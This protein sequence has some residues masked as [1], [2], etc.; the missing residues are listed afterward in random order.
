MNSRLRSL[1]ALWLLLSPAVLQAQTSTLVAV[2]EN[3]S[4]GSSLN[5]VFLSEGYTSAQMGTFAANVQTAVNF[6]FSKEP[7]NRYRSYCNV[8]RIE[9]AS[10]Q[11]GTDNGAAGGARDT[12]WPQDNTPARHSHA[13]AGTLNLTLK[14][15]AHGC[16]T[17]QP[18]PAGSTP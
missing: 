11:S 7:W 17:G 12:R 10:N 4:R 8:Y 18:T 15:S 3:G 5:L 13:A 14:H 6:L 9:I 16:Y 2:E 1:C